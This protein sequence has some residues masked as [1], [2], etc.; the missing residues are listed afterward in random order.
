MSFDSFAIKT[1]WLSEGS[2]GTMT[3]LPIA[4]PSLPETTVLE[5]RMAELFPITIQPHK[6]K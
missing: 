4:A 5:F 6:T 1:P 2:S 3:T